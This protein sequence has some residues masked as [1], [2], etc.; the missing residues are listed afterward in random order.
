MAEKAK[1]PFSL[2]ITLNVDGGSV[3]II[4]FRRGEGDDKEEQDRAS[5]P[6]G[7]LHADV[8]MKNNLYGLSK[9]LQ[10]RTSSES[11]S[12]TRIESMRAVF[13]RLCEGH[14]EKEREAGGPTVSIE[15]EALARFKEVSVAA[16][17]RSLRTVDAATRDRILASPKLAP[18]IAEIRAERAQVEETGVDLSDLEAEAA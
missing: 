18:H 1:S 11:S 15:V 9:I 3:D 16:I 5:F 10:D 4:Q 14:W 7:E 13:T 6:I 8:T 17:Q 12:D 2:D